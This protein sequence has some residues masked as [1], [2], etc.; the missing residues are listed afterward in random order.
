MKTPD[1]IKFLQSTIKAILQEEDFIAPMG[2][3]VMSK[4]IEMIPFWFEEENKH[5][6]LKRFGATIKESNSKE[7]VFVAD[8]T[9]KPIELSQKQISL[10]SERDNAILMIHIQVKER[11][12]EF[13][14]YMQPY[15]K[16]MEGYAFAD[17]MIVSSKVDRA[18]V[19]SIK[20]GFCL[21]KF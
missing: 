8:V 9:T 10:K 20:E 4:G 13:S 17:E 6:I 5:E 18:F 19:F 3:I 11:D 7:A 14:S 12:L 1:V 21:F 15:V 2:F 16:A